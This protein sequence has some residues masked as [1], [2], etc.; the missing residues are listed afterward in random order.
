MKEKSIWKFLK[1]EK[2]TSLDKA[3]QEKE[4]LY[5]SIFGFGRNVYVVEEPF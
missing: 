5:G 1:H 2:N 3:Q 4:L